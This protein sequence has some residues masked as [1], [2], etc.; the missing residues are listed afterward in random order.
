MEH[1]SKYA[2]TEINRPLK[3]EK[4]STLGVLATTISVFIYPITL[5]T[6]P[7][8]GA[9][10]LKNE[11]EARQTSD[12]IATDHE[13]LTGDWTGSSGNIY[14]MYQRRRVSTV[15]GNIHNS[16]GYPVRSFTGNFNGGILD[17]RWRARCTESEGREQ[18]RLENGSLTLI[19]GENRDQN[20]RRMNSAPRLQNY[21]DC[22]SRSIQHD[23][24]WRMNEDMWWHARQIGTAIQLKQYVRDGN[25]IPIREFVGSITPN[26]LTGEL[27]HCGRSTSARNHTFERVNNYYRE[28]GRPLHRSQSGPNFAAN[29]SATCSRENLELQGWWQ[30]QNNRWWNIKKEGSQVTMNRYRRSDGKL[31]S[32]F[33]GSATLRDNQPYIYG[34]LNRCFYEGTNI[35][36]FT[37]TNNM[38]RQEGNGIV[39]RRAPQGFTAAP[40]KIDTSGQC[41]KT[42]NPVQSLKLSK[43]IFIS[44]D[45]VLGT[46]FD[47]YIRPHSEDLAINLAKPSSQ[48]SYTYGSLQ[49]YADRVRICRG[50]EVSSEDWNLVTLD[51]SGVARMYVNINLYEGSSCRRSDQDLVGSY[52]GFPR[53]GEQPLA[54]TLR[55]PI[56]T[57]S[58]GQR[59]TKTIEV[60]SRKTTRFG[61]G[62]STR[63]TY[64][65]ENQT[66]RIRPSED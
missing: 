43:R 39:L 55:N 2:H 63:I 40:F 36:S 28:N 41:S 15:T 37:L 4:A 6:S 9:G 20:L 24:W 58:P 1:Q 30:D 11:I 12:L 60:H 16:Q 50:G 57:V 19:R 46:E 42:N 49:T 17:I 10:M 47:S 48:Q 14:V 45:E 25:G 21:P 54:D 38:I 66:V 22:E 26:S 51:R 29:I 7:A 31:F 35:T 27:R 5:I 33:V 18:W 56:L 61:D 59:K 65:L 34:R 23:G 64:T 44:D 53:N 52:T 32:T 3:A 62:D 8:E 13:T